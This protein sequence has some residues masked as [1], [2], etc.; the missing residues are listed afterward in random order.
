MCHLYLLRGCVTPRKS[1]IN[2]NFTIRQLGSNPGYSVRTPAVF[3][4]LEREVLQNTMKVMTLSLKPP[5]LCAWT[6]KRNN[7][8]FCRFSRGLVGYAYWILTLLVFF[9]QHFTEDFRQVDLFTKLVFSQWQ[10]S[11]KFSKLCQLASGVLSAN[12]NRL[13]FNYTN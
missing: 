8:K 12:N 11:R 2:E 6:G 1:I 7:L 13:K 9:K 4:S 10:F 5:D 3:F